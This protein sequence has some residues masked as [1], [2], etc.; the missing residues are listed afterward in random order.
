M[1]APPQPN[2]RPLLPKDAGQLSYG[3]S[4]AVKGSRDLQ[5]PRVKAAEDSTRVGSSSQ[6]WADQARFLLTPWLGQEPS[7][8]PRAGQGIK[9]RRAPWGEGRGS[10]VKRK[11]ALDPQ[12]PFQAQGT[13]A[14][15]AV[16][17]G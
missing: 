6:P 4:V 5:V 11:A 10:P 13:P 3:S 14:E 17:S 12:K 15:K 1:E 8:R 2:L 16:L 7:L 9:S